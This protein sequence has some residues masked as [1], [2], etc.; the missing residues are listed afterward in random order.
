MKITL[1]YPVTGRLSVLSILFSVLS[2]TA[3]AQTDADAIMMEKNNF[4][5]G[6]MYSYSSWK[7]YWE[8]TFKRDN[9]NFGTVSTKMIGIMGNYGISD[10][11]NVLFSIPYVQTKATAGTLHGQKGVQDLSLWIKYMPFEKKIGPGTL[12]LYAV[13]G[14]SFP[15]T[16]Y[17]VDYLPL[18][19]G[20]RS[21]NI[22]L[23][24]LV[25]YQV[26]NWFAT[27]GVTYINR[28]NIKID[29]DSYYTTELHLTNE[30][31]MPDAMQYQFRAGWRSDR[32][33]AEAVLSNWTTMGGFDIT[34][35]N[36]PFPSNKMNMTAVGVSGKY[37]VKA[38]DGLSI[39]G[40]GNYTVAGRN[41]GQSTGIYGGVFYILNFNKKKK[42]TEQS[43]DK[44]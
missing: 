10:K 6:A 23:R 27:A 5:T 12:S 43:S 41:V 24:G 34:K 20:L 30:V 21:K 33:I 1:W 13:G 44:K 32:F 25:D 39:I 14:F 22:S 2:I 37:N 17:V 15:V 35:N 16:N 36:M 9:A 26:K 4:C 8:G 31:D 18:S 29:R 11:L 40:G 38:V 42:T 19:I 3:M 28:S 7:N